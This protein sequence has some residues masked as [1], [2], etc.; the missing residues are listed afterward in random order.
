MADVKIPLLFFVGLFLLAAC[1]RKNMGALKPVGLNEEN[2]VTIENGNLK[3]VFVDNEAFGTVHRAGYNGIAELYHRVKDS[4]IFVPQYA[5]F[6]LEHVFGGDS[7]AQLFEP[8][9]HPMK[10]FRKGANEIVLYQEATPISGVESLTTFTVNG[11]DYIDV[12]FE[13]ILHND[14]FF[15]HGYAG[16]FWA[17]YI[18]KPEDKRIYFLGTE[19]GQQ[20]IV[21]IEAYSEK[22]G[23]MS[24]H[25]SLKDKNNFYF[26][27][28]FNATLASHNS[29]YR[30]TFPFYYGRFGNM[31]LAFLFESREII[32]F[33]QSPT[34]GGQDSPAWDFQYIIPSPRYGK[35]YSFRA[36]MVYKP[37]ISDQDIKSEYEKWK[38]SL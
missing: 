22:H 33:S 6:N 10:L 12:Q 18:H 15:K 25:R 30:Y 36:R 5:G 34:G 26:A 4:T 38:G 7:L 8:R 28:N 1:S 32:R 21:W 16:L 14:Q 9:L 37:F 24:T 17:S 27:K 13:C 35:K 19:E 23:T 20:D 31:A 2:V 11:P 29:T 3:V